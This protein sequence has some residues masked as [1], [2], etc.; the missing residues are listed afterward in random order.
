MVDQDV[1]RS[2]Q[3]AEQTTPSAALGFYIAFGC[4]TGLIAVLI[5]LTSVLYLRNR[6]QRQE[7]GFIE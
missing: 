1:G 5:A 7:N 4:A 3:A 2:D 6:K